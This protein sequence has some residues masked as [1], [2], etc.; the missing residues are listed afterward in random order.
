[1]TKEF[2]H[3]K[4]TDARVV[5]WDLFQRSLAPVADRQGDA[6]LKSALASVK[7][8]L[9]AGRTMSAIELAVGCVDHVTKCY[10]YRSRES[11]ASADA[12]S[13]LC[14]GVMRKLNQ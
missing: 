3:Y 1:M 8:H 10:G 11:K 5:D 13:A 12:R 6:E 4:A 2:D 7:Q 9:A 14:N